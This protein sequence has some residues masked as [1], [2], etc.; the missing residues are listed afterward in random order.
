MDESLDNAMELFG[1]C[2]NEEQAILVRNESTAQDLRKKAKLGGHILTIEAAKGLDF[3]D[4][5]VYNFLS[6]SHQHALSYFKHGEDCVPEDVLCSELKKLLTALTRT[7][8]RVVLFEENKAKRE[9]FFRF[10]ERNGAVRQHA[11]NDAYLHRK[12][13]PDGWSRKGK[14]AEL[15]P[16]WEVAANCYVQSKEWLREA[17][18]RAMARK[19]QRKID[20]GLVLL[21]CEAEEYTKAMDFVDAEKFRDIHTAILKNCAET[22]AGA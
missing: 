13:T 6:D 21:L 17:F 19:E 5:I 4:I 7:K 3:E 1:Q 8:Q 2:L 11:G 16:N 9:P 15:I 12:A 18:C 14:Q 22:R 10:L 20:L